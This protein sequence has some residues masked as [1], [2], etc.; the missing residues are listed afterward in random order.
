[1]QKE[2]Y[3][4]NGFQ[5]SIRI[6]HGEDLLGER[7]VMQYECGVED[8]STSNFKNEMPKELAD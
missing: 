3:G 2:I 8:V 7:G 6:L 5:T 4:M 1:M